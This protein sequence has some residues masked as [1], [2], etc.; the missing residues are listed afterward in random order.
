[1]TDG[2]SLA[3]VATMAL[4]GWRR[5]AECGRPESD[6]HDTPPQ[7][8]GWSG[9]SRDMKEVAL[10]IYCADIG[11]IKKDKFGWAYVHGERK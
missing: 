6:P 1:M 10:A 8:Y 7:R 11:S 5:L 3:G 9:G 4:R 2:F